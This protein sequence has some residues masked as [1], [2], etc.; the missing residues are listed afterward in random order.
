MSRVVFITLSG[1]ASSDITNTDTDNDTSTPLPLLEATIQAEL[2]QTVPPRFQP[3]TFQLRR[4][5]PRKSNTTNSR[6]EEAEGVTNTW[7]GETEGV[8]QD[9]VCEPKNTTYRPSPTIGMSIGPAGMR[10]GAASLGG[11]VRVRGNL[12]AMSA[13]HAFEQ[14]YLA[15]RPRVTHPAMP[16]VQLLVPPDPAVRPYCIGSV[17]MCTPVGTLRSLLTFEGR[18]FPP[19]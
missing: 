3:L 11:F 4:G 14:A 16:D 18:A 19:G 6:R 7:W 17:A 1:G 10:D 2:A 15:C 12:Y 13:F 9:S 5:S 8:A